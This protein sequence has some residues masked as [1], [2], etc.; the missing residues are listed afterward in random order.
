MLAGFLAR[1]HSFDPKTGRAS[2]IESYRLRDNYSRFFLRY[3][4]PHRDRIEKGLMNDLA[5]TQL[6]GWDT[7]LGLQ[8]ENL[9]LSNID[10][11]VELLSIG[12]AP[13]VY[14]SPHTQK[15]KAR[16]KGCQVDL[17]IATKHS[18]YVVEIKRRRRIDLDVVGEVMEKVERM[19]SSAGR[20]VRTALVYQGELSTRVQDE[21]YFDFI[22]PFEAMLGGS[23]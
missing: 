22:I 3:V 8:F 11:L 2:R 13:L 23:S 6:S 18:L 4:E 21:G 17:L 20:S 9:V 1:D 7:L 14:A 16:R 15:P 10:A 12:R 5:L 19:Q